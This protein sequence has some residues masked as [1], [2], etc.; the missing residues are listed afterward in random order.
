M[1]KIQ[2]ESRAFD[3]LKADLLAKYPGEYVAVHNGEVIDHNPELRTLHLR[4][5]EKYGR[6][7]VLLKQ[8][9]AGPERELVIRSPRLER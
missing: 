9:L 5:Y 6:T 2:A 7:P 4:V 1:R 3:A 8:V